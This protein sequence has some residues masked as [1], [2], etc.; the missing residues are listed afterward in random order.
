[1]I[2]RRMADEITLQIEAL[3]AR[4]EEQRLQ[5]EALLT[6]PRSNSGSGEG[7]S[8]IR[9]SSGPATSFDISKVPDA[10]KLIVPYRGD[11]K[12]L[13]SWIASVDEKLDHAKGLCPSAA[14]IAIVMPLWT[15]I[16]RDKITD[17]ASEALVARHTPCDWD[18]IKKVLTEY[19]GDKRDLSSLVTQICYLKQGS[20]SITIFYN[21]CRELLSD[22]V[23]KL[24][25]DPN[26][27]QNIQTLSRSY[28]DMILNSFID[29]LIEPYSTLV[30]TSCPTTLL[31]AYQ[32]GLDQFN[33]AQRKREKFP[34]LQLLP[35]I[36]NGIPPQSSGNQNRYP[37]NN[38]RKPFQQ[39]SNPNYRPYYQNN[40]R[41]QNPI[42][43]N[44]QPQN[45][46]KFEPPSSSNFRQNRAPQGNMRINCHEAQYESDQ[47]FPYSTGPDQSSEEPYEE[48]VEYFDEPNFQPGSEERNET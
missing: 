24:A 32:R 47:I 6:R 25:L 15:S 3:T 19:F 8:R 22:I 31:L 12:S 34:K 30:R 17:E 5:I 21:E 16:V 36:S 13:A 11:K 42:Q 7:P 9:S 29:G 48:P 44:G 4:M 20:N 26:L 10:I 14:E 23:A 18:N 28:E 41:P 1:M 43:N 2:T 35:N 27:N 38:F 40:F 45:A 37:Q 39:N 46:I 33:A